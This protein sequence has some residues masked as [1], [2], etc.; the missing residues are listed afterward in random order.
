MDATRRQRT[1]RAVALLGI[2]VGGALLVSGEPLRA[3]RTGAFL[4]VVTVMA[5]WTIAENLALQQDEPKSYRGKV[6]TRLMQAAVMIGIYVG[7]F[8]LL[9]TRGTLP[10]EASVALAGLALVAAGGALRVASIL[11]LRRHFSYELRVEAGHRL[12]SAG[13]YRLV[14]HPSYLGILLIAVGAP[15]ALASAWGML[16][17]GGAMIAVLVAR[18]REE[19]AL[20]RDAFGA[21]YEAYSK[22]TWR[23]LPPVW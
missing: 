20:L 10:R 16:A 23:I 18:I 7:T 19:E 3:A 22:R 6:Q 13:P 15:L 2:G 14:R 9:R 21:E 1:L 12:V 8:E 5:V 17:G 4:S 11:T